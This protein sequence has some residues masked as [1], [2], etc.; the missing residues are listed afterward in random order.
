MSMTVAHQDLSQLTSRMIGALSNVQTKVIFGIGRYD[1]EHFAKLIGQVDTEAVKRDSKTD[2]QHELFSSL[3]EQW[4][5]W[6]DRLRFQPPRQATVAGHD[7]KVVTIKTIT[8]SP[9][10]ASDD[11]VEALRRESAARWGIP[12][13]QAERNVQMVAG[14]VP[15]PSSL[16]EG[17][18]VPASSLCAG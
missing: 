6:I 7:G 4:E 16:G 14:K 13:A 18:E 10:S 17:P 5:G 11:R 3:P 8:I 12:Y 9:Y 1:A 2:T 15:P